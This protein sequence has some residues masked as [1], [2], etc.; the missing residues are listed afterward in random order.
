[1]IP[2]PLIPGEG[3]VRPIPA[4]L[5]GGP[6]A[7]AA[8]FLALLVL[9]CIVPLHGQGVDPGDQT[10]R[11]AEEAP[12]TVSR[13]LWLTFQAFKPIG[14]RQFV[15]HAE[16]RTNTAGDDGDWA[17][18]D[19]RGRTNFYPTPW[20]DVFPE[21]LLRY[22]HEAEDVSSFATTLRGGLRV[23]FPNT[24]ALFNRERVPLGRFDFAGLLRLE[25]RHFWYTGGETDTSWRA[26][27][28]AEARFPVN[29]ASLG[30]DD[31]FYLRG[32]AEIFLPL[33]DETPE[34]FANRWRFRMGGG[35]RFSF[36]WRIEALGIW[37]RSRNTIEEDFE[38]TEFMLNL[39]LRHYF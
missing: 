15:L 30:A 20:L 36:P 5:R 14:P 38:T 12:P 27:A 35:Y 3:T 32:D 13:Q 31:L 23:Q 16:A 6:I 9:A 34:T 28:R 29:R 17:S 19:V 1:M 21:L 8:P 4:S 18:V 10:E 22:T 2:A 24:E 25:W 37:Q 39:R 7:A 26:R 11:E 33:D